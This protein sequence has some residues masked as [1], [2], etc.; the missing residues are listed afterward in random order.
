MATTI[1]TS[2]ANEVIVV[3]D[4]LDPG[5]SA[6]VMVGLINQDG[7]DTFPGRTLTP[8]QAEELAAGLAL[9]AATARASAGLAAPLESEHAYRD[10]LNGI[11]AAVPLTGTSQPRGMV[12]S[13][14]PEAN[15]PSP[16]PAA[17]IGDR[18]ELPIAG[19]DDLSATALVKLLS[20][21]SAAER[22]TLLAYEQA[23]RNRKT[24]C[25]RITA[26]QAS[27]ARTPPPVE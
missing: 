23:H 19:Y 22:S 26:L 18:E 2:H 25:Q 8:D 6:V 10:T 11:R 3:D 15:A 13:P 4:A 7:S 20:G 12:H 1:H 5:G 16:P 24:I 27:T 9:S 21:L 17:T 14:P